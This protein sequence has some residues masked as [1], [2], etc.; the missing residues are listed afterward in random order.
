MNNNSCLIDNNYFEQ[1]FNT[2]I[3]EIINEE[4]KMECIVNQQNKGNLYQFFHKQKERSHIPFFDIGNFPD[5]I[6][7]K[8]EGDLV[9]VYICELKKSPYDINQ[10]SRQLFSGYMHA[11]V[12]LNMMDYNVKNI[13][14]KY[15]VILIDDLEI[16]S[17]Y[18]K[19][20]NIPKKTIPGKAL[21]EASVYSRW[22]N[23]EIQFNHEGY[24]YTMNIEKH[25]MESINSYEYSYELNL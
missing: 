21:N 8:F 10:I 20:S 2:K 4:M 23:E 11:K 18:N 16:Q 24:I 1:I 9:E 13:E 7:L 19:L 15:K 5:G 22:E 12:I 6:F 17:E 3:K 25:F 14:Y